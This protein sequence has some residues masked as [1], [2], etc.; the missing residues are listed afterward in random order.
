MRKWQKRKTGLATQYKG[1]VLK[2]DPTTTHHKS[3]SLEHMEPET[4]KQ[5]LQVS[6]TR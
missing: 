3:T 4:G 2:S 1:P 5:E 6:Y